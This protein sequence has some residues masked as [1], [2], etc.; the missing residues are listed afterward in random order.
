MTIQQAKLLKDR[1]YLRQSMVHLSSSLDSRWLK[2]ALLSVAILL[3]VL[4]LSIIV[5][6]CCIAKP[7]YQH[8]KEMA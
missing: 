8:A 6:F 1:L 3:T 2:H 5:C 7:Q 4:F